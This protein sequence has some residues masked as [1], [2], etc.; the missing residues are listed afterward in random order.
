[1]S[2][3]DWLR[4]LFGERD[5]DEG[6]VATPAP[7]APSSVPPAPA[8]AQ[9]PLSPPFN[10]NFSIEDQK[11]AAP[12]AAPPPPPPVVPTTPPAPAAPAVVGPPPRGLDLSAADFLP[13]T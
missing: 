6:A 13:I 1:M 4:R 12:E 10:F 11:A 8:A 9:P 3:F 5:K 7:S 2:F